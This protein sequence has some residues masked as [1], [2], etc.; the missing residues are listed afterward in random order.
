MKK[1]FFS[2]PAAILLFCVVSCH[3]EEEDAFAHAVRFGTAA[4]IEVFL[5]AGHSP[6]YVRY[7][8]AIPW[9]DTSPLW[10]VSG[11][12]EKAKLL[13]SYNADVTKRPYVAAKLGA[14]PIIS[15]RYPDPSLY[16]RGTAQLEKD[17]YKLVSLFLEAGASPNAKW[18]TTNPLLPPTDSRYR[19][20]FE[21]HG[22]SPI[23]YA[24]EAN[25]FSI[26]DLLLKYGAELDEFSLE[27]AQTAAERSGS[28]DM[29]DY[30]KQLWEK[31]QRRL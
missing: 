16:E 5:K 26:V 20:Y 27:R 9:W 17:R 24:I 3:T 15:E 18:G 10:K 11:D 8:G 28:G 30:V 7:R 31:Q 4:D 14:N 25:L 12:Y 13:I 19:K 1:A 21:E 23:N 6:D 29:E 22:D 2:I